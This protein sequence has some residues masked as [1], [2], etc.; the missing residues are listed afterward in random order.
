MDVDQSADTAASSVETAVP[1]EVCANCAFDCVK[2]LRCSICKATSY[3]SAKCQKEDW[4]FHKRNCKKPKGPGDEQLSAVEREMKAKHEQE[5]AEEDLASKDPKVAQQVKQMMAGMGFGNEG[6]KASDKEELISTPP[7]E[8][9]K[10]CMEPCEKPL[11]CGACK[12]AT[13]CSAKCQ[14]GDWQF[15]KRLCKKPV[16]AEPTPAPR[17]ENV[18]PSAGGLSA[19][20][21]PAA[22]F[23]PK[24]SE[25]EVVTGEDVGTWYKHREWQ[26]AE[27]KKEF[28]PSQVS[29]GA[30]SDGPRATAGT[31]VWNKAGTWEEK[32]ML[33]WWQERLSSLKGLFVDSFAGDIT[34]DAI[35]EVTGEAAIVHIRGTPRFLFDLRLKIEFSCKMPRSSRSYK[36]ELTVT[37]FS[38]EL[39]AN[40]GDFPVE[41]IASSDSDKRAVMTSFVPKLQASLRVFVGE[42]GK[43]VALPEGGKFA[44]QLPPAAVTP[45][46]PVLQ[47]TA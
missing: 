45:P 33:P 28:R 46:P 8:T 13:Y 27:E 47:P 42:Y 5:S 30:S 23:S 22:P 18:E 24:G 16:A 29:A 4:R 6:P 19:P 40:E 14:K 26:P 10:N 2:P 36:G 39:S 15:H 17:R 12:V 38:N 43:Q 34:A 25:H 11:R 35:A 32:S 21:A 31:S 7:K 1:S 20:S 41:V 37:E 9:C 44:G 3:C